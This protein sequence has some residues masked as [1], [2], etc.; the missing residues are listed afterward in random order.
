ML[1]FLTLKKQHIIQ[2]KSYVILTTQIITSFPN[3]SPTNNFCQVVFL[4]DS[5]VLVRSQVT[6][7]SQLLYLQV[8]KTDNFLHHCF[9]LGRCCNNSSDN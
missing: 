1:L 8:S 4:A 9:E 7:Y 3:V 2:I 5:F 6:T